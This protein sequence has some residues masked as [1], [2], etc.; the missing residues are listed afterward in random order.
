M[1]LSQKYNYIS[2][3]DLSLQNFWSKYHGHSSPF[4]ENIFWNFKNRSRRFQSPRIPADPGDAMFIRAIS[5]GFRE[6][7]TSP[8]NLRVVTSDWGLSSQFLG[9]L[10]K[11]SDWKMQPW[12]INEDIS[13]LWTWGK[14]QLPCDSSKSS[15]LNLEKRHLW[16]EDAPPPTRKTW[17]SSVAIPKGRGPSMR[18]HCYQYRHR[19]RGWHH[20]T[21]QPVTSQRWTNFFVVVQQPSFWLLFSSKKA[22]EWIRLNGYGCFLPKWQNICILSE[23]SWKIRMM[24]IQA[25]RHIDPIYLAYE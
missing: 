3:H 17:T 16:H 11:K 1:T 23:R 24:K 8:R 14:W 19:S 13:P 7:K 10:W 2:K 9:P 5:Q 22:G 18:L 20:S 15:G 25:D 21:W 4:C 6:C 12:M